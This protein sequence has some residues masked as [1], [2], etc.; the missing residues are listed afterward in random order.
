MPAALDVPWDEIRTK[1]LSG[2]SYDQLADTYGIQEDT[3]RRRSNRCGWKP[4]AVLA[5]QAA[6]KAVTAH[7]SQAIAAAKP[8]LDAAVQEWVDNSKQAAKLIIAKVTDTVP[9]TS[10]PEDIQ[11]LAGALERADTVGRRALGLDKDSP[12]G[13]AVVNIAIGLAYRPSATSGG[14]VMD[15]AQA[16]DTQV[17]G[18]EPASDPVN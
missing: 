18:V 6:R 17:V 12:A 7:V 3:I 10:E 14:L 15:Y 4:T 16:T 1:L 8:A 11:R 2:M 9:V 13:P 5:Q